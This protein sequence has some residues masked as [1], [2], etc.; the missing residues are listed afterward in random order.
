MPRRAARLLGDAGER[1]ARG[2]DLLADERS[3]RV[4]LRRGLQ[5]Q[6]CRDIMHDTRRSTY[7]GCQGLFVHDTRR[8][9][10][11]G[12]QGLFIAIICRGQLETTLYGG[13]HKDMPAC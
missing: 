2:G 10:Y 12:C 13:K 7:K 8:F 6:A 4:R 11:K 1:G 3:L 9:T 5:R